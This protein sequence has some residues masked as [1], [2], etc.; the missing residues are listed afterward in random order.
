MCTA[1]LAH[2]ALR[3]PWRSGFGNNTPTEHGYHDRFSVFSLG[4]KTGSLGAPGS[5][6]EVTQ[7]VSAGARILYNS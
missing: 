2:S 7:V 3:L 6:P 5:L 4:G 1:L